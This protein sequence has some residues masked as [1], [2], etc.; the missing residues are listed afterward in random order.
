MLVRCESFEV[1]TI[2]S[3]FLVNQLKPFGTDQKLN[4]AETEKYCSSF[5]K[6]V[7]HEEDEITDQISNM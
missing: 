6:A 5:S 3:K 7:C 1:G 4:E 2:Q